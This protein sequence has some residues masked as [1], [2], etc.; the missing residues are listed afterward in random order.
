MRSDHD[1]GDDEETEVQHYENAERVQSEVPQRRALVA[2]G[3]LGGR[4]FPIGEPLVMLESAVERLECRSP[5][6]SLAVRT[7]N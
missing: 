3:P 6:R 2:S 5:K 4:S 1:G 7:P